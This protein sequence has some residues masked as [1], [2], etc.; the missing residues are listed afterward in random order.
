MTFIETIDISEQ[1]F[2][3]CSDE[4]VNRF[5]LSYND[6]QGDHG[7]MIWQQIKELYIE[8]NVDNGTLPDGLTDELYDSMLPSRTEIVNTLYAQDG[9]LTGNNSDFVYFDGKYK[10]VYWVD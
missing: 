2:N 1:W 10:R 4:E 3:K 8:V 6:G 7:M 5:L 9:F